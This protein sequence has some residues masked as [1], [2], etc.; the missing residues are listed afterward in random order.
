MN[1]AVWHNLPSGGASRALHQHI[2][3]L[4]ERGHQLTVYTTSLADSTY[5]DVETYAG[6]PVVAPLNMTVRFRHQYRDRV[7]S[8]ALLPDTQV[9]R[10]LAVCEMLGGK[11]NAGGH[12]VVFV[13]SCQ[14]F[15]MPYIGRF[16]TLPTV[17][18][19]GE[20]NRSLF[21]A[22]P[23]QRWAALPPA[24]GRWQAQAYR[25]A[26]WN[27]VFEQRKARV[28]VR[29]EIANY[30]TYNTVLVNS[31]F[32]NESVIRAYG[33]GANVCY[34]GIDTSLF[35]FLDLPRKPFVLGLGA[36]F[37]HKRPDTAIRALAEVPA[38][39][40]P[41]LVWVGNMGNGH[42][43]GQMNTLAGQLG[44]DFQ[45]REGIAQ[46]DLVTLL[47]TATCL[48][49]TSGLEPFGF[50]PLEANACGLP[51]VA[52]AEGGIRE[53]V[54]DGKN[55]LLTPRDP[56]QIAAAL[57]QLMADP[58]LWQRLSDT[59]R[60]WV[61]QHWQLNAAVDRV[62]QALMKVLEKGAVG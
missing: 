33:H 48:L 5:L 39:H 16:L 58:A 29:E 12:D 61:A 49:Y 20:P 10:M 53:T 13:N 7:R 1:I 35:P 40:R 51:T 37:P 56:V 14:H 47:N 11:V 46:A 19:L 3:G 6:K 8:L 42:Y 21:E 59:G 9:E 52:V 4:A 54:I 31:F 43:L 22:F 62:E 36:F 60:T 28:R 45:A 57:Q 38:H 2:E 18:Y 17:L 25:K 55:G 27:D 34:L 44:V 32:S 30:H 15:M 26:W 24:T 41:A 23:T 50:A